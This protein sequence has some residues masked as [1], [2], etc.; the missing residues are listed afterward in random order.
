MQISEEIFF[1]IQ[2]QH[3]Q[4]PWG[5]NVFNFYKDKQR[6]PYDGSRVSKGKNDRKWIHGGNISSLRFYVSSLPHP[7]W[8]HP[9]GNFFFHSFAFLS[10]FSLDPLV[11]YY[12]S[13][14]AINFKNVN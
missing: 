13:I 8:R 11:Y 1:Y 4:R 7:N 2:E 6:G 14:V 5:K 10:Y 12:A 9:I 3:M